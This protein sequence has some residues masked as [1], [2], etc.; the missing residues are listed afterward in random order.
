MTVNIPCLQDE[1]TY[2][3]KFSNLA[4][5]GQIRGINYYSKL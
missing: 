1:N 3:I 5:I 4:Q 2:G